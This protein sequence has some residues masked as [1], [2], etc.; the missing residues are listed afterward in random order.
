MR[1]AA[2]SAATGSESKL[3]SRRTLDRE[4]IPKIKDV[5]WEASMFGIFRAFKFG[6][7]ILAAAILLTGTLSQSH[8]ATGSVRIKITSFG[9]L[10]GAGGGSGTLTFRKRNYSLD[11]AGVS[12]GTMGMAGVELVGT[13]TNLHVAADIEGTY[14]GAAAGIAVVRGVK[15]AILRNPNRVVLRLRGRKVGPHVSLSLNSLTIFLK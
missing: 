13:A 8:A 7:A 12:A 10:F 1:C 4:S 11:I 2:D 15:V 6:A 5:K 14:S 3:F 9:L